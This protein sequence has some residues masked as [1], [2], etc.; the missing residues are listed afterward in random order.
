MVFDEDR[1][2]ADVARSIGVT[3]GTLGN[4]VGQERIEPGDREGMTVDERASSPI[5]GPSCGWN[6]ICSN[7]R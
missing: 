7:D 4:W 2:I 5:C 3:T 6:E 1:L